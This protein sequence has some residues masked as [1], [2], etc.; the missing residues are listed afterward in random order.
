MLSDNRHLVVICFLIIQNHINEAVHVS[1]IDLTIFIYVTGFVNDLGQNHI[2]DG[3]HVGNIDLT[4]TIHVTG[5]A[6]IGDFTLD[7]VQCDGRAESLVDIAGREEALLGEKFD[8][9]RHN[10]L[11]IGYREPL[12]L[13]VLEVSHKLANTSLIGARYSLH[14]A[15][16]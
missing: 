15:S 11:A 8:R 9:Q 14:V 1:N 16:S 2:D 13:D 6:R 7:E 12:A 4:V 5:L 3:I 10:A